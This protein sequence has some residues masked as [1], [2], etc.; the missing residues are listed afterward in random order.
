MRE[1]NHPGSPAD[2]L[3]LLHADVRV[4]ILRFLNTKDLVR[5]AQACK[6][7]RDASRNDIIWQ[8]ACERDWPPLCAQSNSALEATGLAHAGSSA[9]GT[10]S[11][12]TA[13][14]DAN[15]SLDQSI[16]YRRWHQYLVTAGSRLLRNGTYARVSSALSG[17]IGWAR[18]HFPEAVELTV[19][20]KVITRDGLEQQAAA[21]RSTE[22]QLKHDLPP[23]LKALWLL[24]DGQKQ[25]QGL[26][27]AMF[28]GLL[29]GCVF[30]DTAV[31]C[32]FIS[33]KEAAKFATSLT[34]TAVAVGNCVP[35]AISSVGN[36]GMFLVDYG[37][38]EAPVLALCG[39][40]EAW[41]QVLPLVRASPAGTGLVEWLEEYGR[42]LHSGMY[43][44]ATLP[45]AITHDDEEEEEDA[46]TRE[47]KDPS[48]HYISLHP[49][50]GPGTSHAVTR[51]IHVHMSAVMVPH[52]TAPGPDTYCMPTG[53]SAEITDAMSAHGQAQ[54]TAQY[55]FTYRARLW[56]DGSALPSAQLSHRHWRIDAG[57]GS[58]AEEVS[59]EGV[60][61]LYPTLAAPH[62]TATV[63]SSSSAAGAGVAASPSASSE[64]SSSSSSFSSTASPIPAPGL[65]VIA[66][67]MPSQPFEYC[68]ATTASNS[69]G[70]SMGGSFRMVP[71]T[72]ERP[73]Q[74]QEPFDAA[75]AA[76]SLDVPGYIF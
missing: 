17:I 51:G 72:I 31:N 22:Q 64:P 2:R 46:A 26:S 44:V 19:H 23:A 45:R 37:H 54:R 28:C 9:A 10:S 49:E 1:N 66:V 21:I 34:S 67:R 50:F 68:S 4:L 6:A 48:W 36:N 60:I 76:W 30:Y 16:H 65:D 57:D 53:L 63:T 62:E 27:R 40:R 43:R 74:G 52:M 42:R 8:A 38:E 39:R 71:G 18:E 75:V 15:A 55:H 35:I 12:L 70:G 56:N 13:G 61:G 5:A 59:G 58:E 41:P 3:T 69:T 11:A 29:G 25:R 24:L 20:P 73:M 47:E 32:R 7:L 33:C 14:S